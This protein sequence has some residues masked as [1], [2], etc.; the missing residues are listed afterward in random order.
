MLSSPST[1]MAAPTQF[2]DS[3]LDL[4]GCWRA[5]EDADRHGMRSGSR[6]QN[7]VEAVLQEASA[8]VSD[9]QKARLKSAQPGAVLYYMDRVGHESWTPL[10]TSLSHMS[11]GGH[12]ATTP[13]MSVRPLRAS[14]CGKNKRRHLLAML[15]TE[16][17]L[18]VPLEANQ[19]DKAA[20][21]FEFNQWRYVQCGSLDVDQQKPPPYVVDGL[22]KRGASSSAAV[23]AERNKV[24]PFT[25]ER[26]SAGGSRHRSPAGTSRAVANVLFFAES[27]PGLDPLSI[28][29]L[30]AKVFFHYRA[31]DFLNEH[32][33][34]VSR[35]RLNLSEAAYSAKA[36]PA[37][38]LRN[39]KDDLRAADRYDGSVLCS[40]GLGI[41][42]LALARHVLG[43]KHADE[44]SFL[45]VRIANAKMGVLVDVHDTNDL[46]INLPESVQKFPVVSMTAVP[47]DA[48]FLRVVKMQL[49][50]E[51]LRNDYSMPWEMV[52]VLAGVAHTS[53]RQADFESLLRARQRKRIDETGRG[54]FMELQEAV[55]LRA[56]LK[57]WSERLPAAGAF[58]S[59]RGYKE[60]FKQLATTALEGLDRNF[61]EGCRVARRLARELELV[62]SVKRFQP[63]RVAEQAYRPFVAPDMD[64]RLPVDRV[65]WKR[66]GLFY[67]GTVGVMKNPCKLLTG[68]Q[69]YR[70]VSEREVK[71]LF[72]RGG[73]SYAFEN[74]LIMPA[75]ARNGRWVFDFHAGMDADGDAPL[76]LEDEELLR[77]LT[78][79]LEESQQI[80]E[81][82]QVVKEIDTSQLPSVVDCRRASSSRQALSEAITAEI[83]RDAGEQW[84]PLCDTA[85]TIAADR[86][87][88][89]HAAAEAFGFFCGL[90]VDK[91]LPNSLVCDWLSANRSYQQYWPGGTRTTE[92]RPRWY[93][94][95]KGNKL[96]FRG[97]QC[98]TSV[99]HRLWQFSVDLAKG[100]DP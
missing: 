67:S 12:S 35:M 10:L 43:A 39:G 46:W 84:L 3:L 7:F 16:R 66:N 56:R 1:N 100:L 34:L 8:P 36:I 85:W 30:F 86:H 57:N 29:E 72:P 17:F 4:T 65:L 73:P 76:V 44:I 25:S 28:D 14:F 81:L 11:D 33:K 31:V 62:P 18:V 50:T 27:G 42:S 61:A 24:I 92:L 75:K 41:M 32:G 52:L 68:F 99:L 19:L 9:T 69:K 96:A 64:Q 80:Q 47:E 51:N 74:I 48:R 53:G 77:L 5:A 95:Y 88:V 59:K 90:A 6:Y 54:L 40:D 93:L 89:Q 13:L 60:D 58:G 55:T 94:E 2:T 21:S 97:H 83:H 26:S 91:K 23:F 79:I 78:P 20:L 45:Q 71:E 82:Q 22:S 87:G 38:C 70:G 49:R 98:D 63:L 15:G 37:N